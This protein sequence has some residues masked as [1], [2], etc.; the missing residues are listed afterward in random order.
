MQLELSK[1]LCTNTAGT[2][3]AL[4]REGT[5]QESSPSLVPWCPFQLL[6]THREVSFLSLDTLSLRS[7]K[8]GA[9]T[10]SEGRR[11]LAREQMCRAHGGWLSLSLALWARVTPQLWQ[12]LC[13]RSLNHRPGHFLILGY[14][15]SQSFGF[16][17]VVWSMWLC[18]TSETDVSFPRRLWGN[19]G[20]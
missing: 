20:L 13:S 17:R 5:W 1:R 10:K 18:T 2:G 11:S 6:W 14:L 15:I 16:L 8:E 7:S 3:M 4:L 9:K 19:P 12:G